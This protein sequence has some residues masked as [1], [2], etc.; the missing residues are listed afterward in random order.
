MGREQ[1]LIQDGITGFEIGR[2]T[3]YDQANALKMVAKFRN[4]GVV[5]L[6]IEGF[7]LCDDG[8]L[9]PEMGSIADYSEIYGRERTEAVQVSAEA[10]EAF[11][12]HF[13]GQGLWFEFVTD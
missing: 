5:I 4:E 10:A 12:H 2:T 3:L 1:K 9:M 11:L 13:Q 8:V 6:G 7:Y